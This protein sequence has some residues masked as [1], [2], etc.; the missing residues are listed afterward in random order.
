MYKTWHKYHNIYNTLTSFTEYFKKPKRKQHLQTVL[1]DAY[2][3]IFWLECLPP[4]PLES[5]PSQ[6]AL[7][8]SWTYSSRLVGI[9]QCIILQMSGQSMPNTKVV[10]AMTRWSLLSAFVK[11]DSTCSLFSLVKT[12]LYISVVLNWD[13]S[14]WQGGSVNALPSLC[15]SMRKRSEQSLYWWTNMTVFGNSVHF[16]TNSLHRSSVS[17]FRF[18]LG[19]SW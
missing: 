9:P 18:A 15:R 17:S 3:F 8:D 10:V 12:R 11:D 14:G 7:P 5:T 2:S 13:T 6:P 16:A 19:W 4:F 1:F